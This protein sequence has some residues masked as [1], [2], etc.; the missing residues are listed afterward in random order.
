M[1]F[2][3]SFFAGY[4]GLVAS[5]IIILGFLWAISGF[6]S[7]GNLTERQLILAFGI[8]TYVVVWQSRDYLG[9]K[10]KKIEERLPLDK[11]AEQDSAK[12]E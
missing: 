4:S 8:L 5:F 6:T 7:I 9:D 1:G 12:E 10:L 3:R 11:P 2:L